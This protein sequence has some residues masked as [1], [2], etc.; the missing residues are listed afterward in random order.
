MKPVSAS[1][2]TNALTFDESA[3]RNHAEKFESYVLASIIATVFV[4]G[5]NGRGRSEIE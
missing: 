2:H 1:K 5:G 3:D 4:L